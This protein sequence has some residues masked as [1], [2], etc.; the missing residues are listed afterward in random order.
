MHSFTD[1]AALSVNGVEGVELAA[2]RVRRLH[3]HFHMPPEGAD[4]CRLPPDLAADLH[5]GRCNTRTCTS[6]G[7]S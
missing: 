1:L 3:T 2:N 7:L 5:H 4:S 6:E